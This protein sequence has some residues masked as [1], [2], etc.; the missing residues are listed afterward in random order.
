MLYPIYNNVYILKQG[1]QMVL[2]YDFTTK[3]IYEL[4]IDDLDNPLP[5]GSGY[6]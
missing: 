2:N 3:Q 1:T 5:L 4:R 6:I